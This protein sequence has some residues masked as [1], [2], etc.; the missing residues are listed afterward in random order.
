MKQIWLI[1]REMFL[2]IYKIHCKRH[3]PTRPHKYRAK[4]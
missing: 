2:E 1:S 4:V 3:Q